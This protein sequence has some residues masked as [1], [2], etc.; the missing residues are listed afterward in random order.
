MSSFQYKNGGGN[1]VDVPVAAHPDAEGGSI[2]VVY[3][4]PK[5]RDGLGAPCGAVGQPEIVV[6]FSRMTGTGWNFWQGFFASA[7]L[8]DVTL[9]GLTAFDP[10]SGTWKKY[11]GTL[12]R[13]TAETIQAGAS[14]ARTW[15]RE[16]V[17]RVIE[18]AET[19]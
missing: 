15:Y 11:T 2:S 16:G 14:A 4:E 9:T 6:R 12:L 18:I 17:L 8:L 3:P 1:W 7:A 13:P 5:A 10:R 19:T